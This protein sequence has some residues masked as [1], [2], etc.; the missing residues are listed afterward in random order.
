MMRATAVL[1][2][3]LHGARALT[4]V[5]IPLDEGRGAENNMMSTGFVAE[6]YGTQSIEATEGSWTS[7]ASFSVTGNNR[8]YLVEDTWTALN[9]DWPQVSYKMLELAGKTLSFTLDVSGV[10]CGCDASVYLVA[11]QQ[12]NLFGPNYCDIQ[13]VDGSVACTEIDLFEGNRMA[14]QSTLHTRTGHG[15]DVTC[16]QEG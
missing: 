8:A 1:F 3:G 10:G 13:S 12:P 11:M 2:C 14:V 6:P 5:P 15:A 16:N 7:A 9:F 4:A